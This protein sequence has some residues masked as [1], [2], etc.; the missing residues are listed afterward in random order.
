MKGI[1]R[2]TTYFVIDN[3]EIPDGVLM[4]ILLRLPLKSIFKFKCVSK[5]WLSVIS[6]PYLVTSFLAQ[7][8]KESLSPAWDLLFCY[9]YNGGGEISAKDMAPRL[10]FKNHPDFKPRGFSL[11][12][13]TC[14]VHPQNQSIKVLAASN[15]LMLM[16][17]PRIVR[18]YMLYL[19]AIVYNEIMHWLACHFS[20]IAY[21]PNVNSGQCRSINLPK[22]WQC[23]HLGVLGLCRETPLL[24]P[25]GCR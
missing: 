11:E 12:F 4:E 9:M 10:T 8:K 20:I 6:D 15:G 22:D 13:L 25:R 5:R 3:S 1:T 19:L 24:S 17:C 23:P 18:L 7:L 2:T 14:E 21:D 16:S